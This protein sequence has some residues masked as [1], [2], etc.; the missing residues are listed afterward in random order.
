MHS[1]GI[2]ASVDDSPASAPLILVA[3]RWADLLGE[4][5]AV[6]TVGEMAPESLW[7][8]PVRR[9]FGPDGDP[10]AFLEDLVEPIRDQRPDVETVAVYDPISPAEGVRR[11][12][13]DDPAF[14]LVVSSRPHSGPARVSPEALPQQS[15]TT[16]PRPSWSFP[17]HCDANVHQQS[18][19]PPHR[20][21][22]ARVPIQHEPH[23]GAKGKSDGRERPAS[24]AASG[25]AVAG[26]LIGQSRPGLA[27]LRLE[28]ALLPD[29]SFIASGACA[30]SRSKRVS[31]GFPHTWGLRTSLRRP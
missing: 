8:G 18:H 27:K 2:V 10:A 21:T 1:H 24:T 5:L 13:R 29:D 7:E 11:Y 15:F 31:C 17:V 23:D 3:L 26:A 30:K 28:L 20:H 4:S 9:R 22:S 16:A 14:L 19:Q 12:L 25:P 6:I